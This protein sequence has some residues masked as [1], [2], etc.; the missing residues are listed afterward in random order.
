MSRPFGFFDF[1]S[2][3]SNARCV[4]SDSGTVPEECAIMNVP[5]VILRETTERP[6]M[7]EAGSSLLAGTEATAILR[8]LKLVLATPPRWTPPAEYLAENV[9]EK[10]ARIILGV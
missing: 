3:S 5:C 1:I 4:L 10:V 6:E 7:L 8:G 9:S 2:L